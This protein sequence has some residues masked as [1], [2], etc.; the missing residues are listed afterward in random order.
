MVLLLPDTRRVA[1]ERNW[2]RYFGGLP[3]LD[4]NANRFDVWAHSIGGI[5]LC[6]MSMFPILIF[7]R[8]RRL[9][10]LIA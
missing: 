7:E 10:F 3:S 4:G 1:R 5:G 9:F 8:Q 2:E 6:M